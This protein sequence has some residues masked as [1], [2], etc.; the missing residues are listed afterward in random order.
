MVEI[1]HSQAPH[2][3]ATAT[4]PRASRLAVPLLAV[5]VV[6]VVAIVLL[7]DK[8][9]DAGIVEPLE[10][11]VADG[12]SD[13]DTEAAEPATATPRATAQ[14]PPTVPAATTEFPDV[15]PALLPSTTA[16]HLAVGYGSTVRYLD[17]ATGRWTESD[18]GGRLV[19]E[20]GWESALHQFGS[21]VLGQDDRGRLL[22]FS[23]EGGRPEVLG[24][25]FDTWLLGVRQDVAYVERPLSDGSSVV[26][27]YSED[28]T[29][30]LQFD[31][32]P[33]SDLAGLD[34]EGRVIVQAG[35]GIHAIGPD[36]TSLLAVGQVVG[37]VDHY[38]LVYD[39]DARL[40]CATDLVHTRT[41]ERRATPLPPGLVELDRAQ[42][43]RV[44]GAWPATFR[45]MDGQVVP[46]D[47]ASAP[48]LA[49]LTASVAPDGTI[50]RLTI[51]GI[52]LQGAGSEEIFTIPYAGPSRCCSQPVT[53]VF[54][55][56]P[57]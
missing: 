22:L 8:D 41:G 47:A 50:A 27:G 57:E 2:T 36:G 56:L 51:E 33:F 18:V 25:P 46:F 24:T 44:R 5:G 40:E 10:P 53:V 54:L 21:G 13:D 31:V 15:D 4:R 20:T 3:T 19:T 35:S 55:T 34:A 38:A 49:G 17:L 42:V 16:T 32:P 7:A 48:D 37:V 9:T 11:S 30:A 39:C 23:V 1:T 52:E 45:L 12:I 14:A 26:E 43:L 29:V 6:A 28:G